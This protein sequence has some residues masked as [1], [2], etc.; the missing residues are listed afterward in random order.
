MEAQSAVGTAASALQGLNDCYT[1]HS[2]SSATIHARCGE[3]EAAKTVGV[4]RSK[5]VL[6]HACTGSPRC[7]L[8]GA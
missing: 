4:T 3:A 2:E 7:A 8:S 1:A 6:K 5:P